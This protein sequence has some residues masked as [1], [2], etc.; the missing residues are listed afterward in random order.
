M[1]VT[2]IIKQ[3]NIP[4][5]FEFFPPKT[6]KGWDN[7]FRT[8]SELQTL[9]PAY[10]SVTYGAGGSTRQNTHSLVKRIIR[11]TDLTVVAHLTC[12]HS[13][14]D[15][16][17]RIIESY[18]EA[19]VENILALRGDAADNLEGVPDDITDFQFASDLIDYI[20]TIAPDMCIGAA[21]FP[22]GHPHTPN[23]LKEM[24]YLRNKVDAG[25]DYLVSQLFFENRDFLDFCE[26]AA[27]SGI[28][29]PVIAGIMPITS[30]TGMQRMA[31]LAAGARFPA[32]LLRALERGNESGLV[33]EVGV[34]WATEQ[35]RDL[36]DRSVPGIHLYTLNNSNASIKICQSLG[37]KDYSSL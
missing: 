19:G 10:V 12:I 14:R 23:R 27:I 17:K 18:Q 24:E 16:I 36:I 8:I 2:D 15:E 22:E 3:K 13:K 20:R 7:L 9:K 4:F 30:Y 11:E 28:K 33:S 37:L 32:P 26:R 35:V 1:K 5:S 31:D 25:V 21:C 34:Q 6:T 29:V